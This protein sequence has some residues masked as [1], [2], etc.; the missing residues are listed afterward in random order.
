MKKVLTLLIFITAIFRTSAQT[1]LPIQTYN[2]SIADCINYAYEHQNTVVNANLDIKSAEYRVKETIGI[3]LPQI[4]G[5]ATFTDYLR[6]PVTLIP[7]EF[8][9]QPGT[10]KVSPI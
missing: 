6:L 2:F 1:Q 7:G 4:N 9:G 5:Q 3:G 10:F 8:I